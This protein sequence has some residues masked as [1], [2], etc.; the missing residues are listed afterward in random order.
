MQSL[1]ATTSSPVQRRSGRKTNNNFARAA[2]RKDPALETS[3]KICPVGMTRRVDRKSS[4]P[5]AGTSSSITTGPSSQGPVSTRS[6]R[7]LLDTPRRRH[8]SDTSKETTELFSVRQKALSSIELRLKRQRKTGH[9][10]MRPNNKDGLALESVQEI[11]KKVCPDGMTRR[12]GSKASEPRCQTLETTSS[13]TAGPSSQGPASA[14]SARPLLDTPRRHRFSENSKQRRIEKFEMWLPRRPLRVQSARFSRRTEIKLDSA[15]TS[16][17]YFK[18][19]VPKWSD[20][21]PPPSDEK[22]ISASSLA[23]KPSTSVP[24]GAPQV[25]PSDKS[26]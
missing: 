5:M 9:P 19:D 1:L 21:F 23:P 13:I 14:R 12:A 22:T 17:Q 6:A 20:Y 3:T 2:D 24:L 26:R 18:L 15:S 11:V 8:I 16:Q 4:E 10:Y 25:S 7:P